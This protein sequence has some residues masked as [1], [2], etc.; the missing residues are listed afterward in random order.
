LSFPGHDAAAHLARAD[1]VLA[2]IAAKAW[3]D[4]LGAYAFE[5]GE[6]K[7]YL[8]PNITNM[9]ANARAAELTGDA[10]YLARFRALYA[11]IQPLK[12]AAGDHYFSPYSAAYMGATDEDYATLSSQNYLMLALLVGYRLTGEAAW[13]EE[14]G[15]LLGFLETHLLKD[16][17][18]LHHWMNGGPAIPSHKEYYCS[19]CNL[20]TLYLL[21]LM[22]DAPP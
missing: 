13:L 16:G 1:A 10:K 19:G 4:A 20:Q 11:G 12:A 2:A 5:P 6:P 17:Q 22:A 9:L 7:L 14:I 18:I 15:A 3:D 21:A 8:Y